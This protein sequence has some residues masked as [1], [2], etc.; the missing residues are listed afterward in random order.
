MRITSSPMIPTTRTVRSVR[1]FAESFPTPDA[2]LA[3]AQRIESTL[4][5]IGRRQFIY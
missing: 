3:R 5:D 1:K 2:P 4:Q